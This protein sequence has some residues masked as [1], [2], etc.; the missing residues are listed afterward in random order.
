MVDAVGRTAALD[1]V[2]LALIDLLRRNS[3]STYGELGT[4]VGLSAPAAK[5]RVDRLIDQGVVRGFTVLLDHDQLGRPLQAFTELRFAGDARVDEI[6]AIGETIPE[7]VG[8]FTMAGDPDALAWLRVR[9]VH[10]LKRVVDRIRSTGNIIGT[11]TMI[12]LAG[13]HLPDR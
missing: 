11:K 3:R 4:R 7:V 12:V 1:D 8:V 10:D 9:D 6:A 5:R 13:P 2:D